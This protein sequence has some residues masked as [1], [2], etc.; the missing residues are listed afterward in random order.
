[1]LR[2]GESVDIQILLQPAFAMKD[3]PHRFLVQAVQLSGDQNMTKQEWSALSK[4]QIY[5]QRLT[6]ID[7]PSAGGA[8]GSPADNVAPGDLQ[9][10]YEELVDYVL[11][12]EKETEGLEKKRNA[13]KAK[14]GP[15]AGGGFQLWHIVAA[16][17]VVTPLVN[18]FMP[19]I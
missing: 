6:V 5:E 17:A 13:L 18:Q 4:D 19:G 8:A 10:K 3:Q 9:T 2:K 15:G 12:L 14:V 16:V 1:M 7:T 11:K